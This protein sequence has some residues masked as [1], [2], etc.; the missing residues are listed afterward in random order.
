MT[1]QDRAERSAREMLQGDTASQTLGMIITEIAPG[2]ATLTMPVTDAMLNGHGICH[3][4]YIF[5]LADS[6]FAFACNTYN[7]RTVAQQNQITYLAPGQPN[8]TLT[9]RAVEVSRTGRSGIYDVTV[10]ASDGTALALFR[11]LS[12]T[13]KGQIFPEEEGT[14]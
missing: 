2:R 13:I 6:A 9:A 5:T 8:D 3:G 12:R 7:Q 11:G 1:P 4:G 14:T 10:T